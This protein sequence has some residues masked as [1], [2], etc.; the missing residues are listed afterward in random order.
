MLIVF[1]KKKLFTSLSLVKHIHPHQTRHSVNELLFIPS[2]RTLSSGLNSIKYRSA[3]T[4]N[5]IAMAF[6]NKKLFQCSRKLVKQ[7][8]K[9]DYL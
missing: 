4:W 8:L 2:V 9:M 3:S 1:C 5:A 7:T 6:P